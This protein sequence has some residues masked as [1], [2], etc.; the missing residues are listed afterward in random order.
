MAGGHKASQCTSPRRC[1]KFSRK[2]HQSICG[3]LSA[4]PVNFGN[5]QYPASRDNQESNP[6]PNSNTTTTTAGAQAHVLLQTA[7]ARACSASGSWLTVCVLLDGG[8]QKSYITDE[9]KSKLG[10][11]PTNL[12]ALNLNTFG[13]DLCKRKQCDLVKL[14]LQGKEGVTIEM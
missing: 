9:L 11:N 2:H 13:S 1:R 6:P 14:K 5:P 4:N 3:T 12:E 8:S 7:K 10:L